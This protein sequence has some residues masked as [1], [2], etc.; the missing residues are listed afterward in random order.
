PTS[1]Y[2]TLFRSQQSL[3]NSS[4]A[5]VPVIGTQIS[6]NVHSLRGSGL[7]LAVRIAL[8]LWSGL[9]VLKVTQ[10]AMNT[11]WNVPHKARP[12]FLAS[13]LRAILMLAGL[14]TLTLA[15]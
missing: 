15:S 13:T 2:T 8:T 7:T 4:I 14:G 11:M 12:N 3:V 9:G 5:T 1:P 10:T 6:R